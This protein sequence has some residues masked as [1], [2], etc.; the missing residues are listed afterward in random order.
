MESKINL[1]FLEFIYTN[2]DIDTFDD[3]LDELKKIFYIPKNK[4]LKKTHSNLEIINT[5][6][7]KKE[8]KNSEKMINYL[9]NPT[10][11]RYYFIKP[12]FLKKDDSDIDEIITKIDF[13]FIIIF[14]VLTILVIIGIF[15]ITILL[16]TKYRKNKISR[17]GVVP[18]I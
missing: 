9:S 13:H 12:V 17:I 3:I 11:F 18:N 5:G 1:M 10:P 15:A 8:I 16:R 6:V 7:S 2:S 14:I 4:G